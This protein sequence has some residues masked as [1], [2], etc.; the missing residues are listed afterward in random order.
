MHHGRHFGRA[1]QAFCN[2]HTL[3]TQG[4]ARTIQLELGRIDE[5]DFTNQCVNC[6]IHFLTLTRWYRERWE[7]GVYN[8]LLLMSP[9]LEERLCTTNKQDVGYIAEMV[10]P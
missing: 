2:V 10:R 1:V 8:K 3:L 6:D 5:R 4:I 9:T 7:H